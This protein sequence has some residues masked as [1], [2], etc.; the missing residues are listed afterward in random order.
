MPFNGSGS[1]V[2]L[3]APNY[4]A[5]INTII[6]PDYYNNNLDDLFDG[7]SAC[8]TRDGQSPA[9][10]NLPMAGYKHTNAGVAAAAGQ[11][12]VYGQDGAALG[13]TNITT[14]GQT[15]S[16]SLTDTG[17]NG[18]GLR[19]TGNG[20]TTPSKYIRVLSGQ[21]EVIN[22]AYSA[23]I[24]TL[25]DVGAM[26][27]ASQLITSGSVVAQ[28]SAGYTA[29]TGMTIGTN[30]GNVSQIWTNMSGPA[31]SKHWDSQTYTGSM[32]WRALNDTLAAATTWMQLDRV[33]YVPSNLTLVLSGG[34]GFGVPATAPY[35]LDFGVAGGQI[36]GVSN[37]GGSSDAAA[38]TI[39]GGR[40]VTNGG[41]IQFYGGSHATNANQ[42]LLG[43][44][45]SHRIGILSD[46]RIYGTALHNVGAV[47]GTA[48]QFIASLSGLAPTLTAVSGAA[49]LSASAANAIRVG[50]VV[51]VAGSFGVT[52]TAGVS[53]VVGIAFP[54]ASAMTAVAGY[55]VGTAVM[56][57][58]S[59]GF[60][61]GFID[62]D[63]VNDRA[64]FTITPTTTGTYAVNYTYQYLIL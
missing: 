10:A 50:N 45:G 16:L 27:L 39:W 64:T 37:I 25:S 56:G 55:V 35:K 46:G 26:T 58:G 36:G 14:T 53:C 47:T 48:Q 3:A 52:V 11:Y 22:S 5:V 8:I 21:L 63:A 33:G 6:D 54:I 4:P 59:G 34:L 61:A 17:V 42:L 32:V 2:P 7:L 62:G 9:T 60:P 30:S 43:T 23:V 51:S 38:Y 29:T 12:L 13:I 41:F 1:F 31:D 18:V 40:T 15:F 49:G 20:A 57:A 28:G 19:M 24:A 44:N